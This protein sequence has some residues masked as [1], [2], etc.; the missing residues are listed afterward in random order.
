M[1]TLRWILGIMTALSAVGLL[2]LVVLGNGFRRSFGASGNG[3]AKVALLLLLQGAL[4]VSIATP[5][6]AWWLH[7]SAVGMAGLIVGC[8]WV[9]RESVFVGTTGLAYCGLW[10][11]YY[12]QVAWAPR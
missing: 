11:C 7:V 8:L 2:A 4:L 3:G 5:E 12:W 1:Q 6:W 10:I 9:C